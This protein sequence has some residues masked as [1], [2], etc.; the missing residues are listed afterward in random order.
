M[1]WLLVV[2]WYALASVCSLVLY[3]LDKRRAR[4]DARRVPE[5]RLHL[6]DAVGGWPGGLVARRLFR[7]KT[8]KAKFLAVSRGI[9][10]LHALGWSAVAWVAGW[11]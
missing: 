10:L 5:G 7:H 2:A 4:H 9:I 11:P 3:R 1:L 6:I 8:R